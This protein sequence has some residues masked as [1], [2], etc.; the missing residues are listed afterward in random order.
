LRILRREM[1]PSD[2]VLIMQT[3]PTIDPI[4]DPPDPLPDEPGDQ[5][6][7]L[8]DADPVAPDPSPEDGVVNN[9]K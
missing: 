8:P 4:A 3:V 2:Q 6:Q 1:F 7:P 9:R 5:P